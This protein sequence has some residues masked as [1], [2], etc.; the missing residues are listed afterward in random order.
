MMRKPLLTTSFL[1]FFLAL[2]AQDTLRLHSI[3]TDRQPLGDNGYTLNGSQMVNSRAKL[4]NPDNFG[5]N[6]T[7]GK[8]ILIIDG[9]QTSGSLTGVGS[10][11][12]EDIFFF[13]AFD[14]TS[15]N[16]EQFSQ[17]EKDS[18]YAWSKRGGKLIIGASSSAQA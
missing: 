13:G 14:M 3:S 11:P 8:E 9:Y 2:S 4:E 10:I 1:L 12:N 5:D 16:M 15:N 6:G 7:Y 18:L 17:E